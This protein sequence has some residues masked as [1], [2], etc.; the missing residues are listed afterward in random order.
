MPPPAQVHVEKA[1]TPPAEPAKLDVVVENEELE[2]AK[3]KQS[4]IVQPEAAEGTQQNAQVDQDDAHQ[5]VQAESHRSSAKGAPMALNA[6]S[7]RQSQQAAQPNE[8]GTTQVKQDS[9]RDGLN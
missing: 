5:V 4:S 9:A 7:A 3:S 8:S 6:D 1:P 2:V